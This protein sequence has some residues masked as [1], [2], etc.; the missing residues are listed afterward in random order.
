[1]GLS[2]AAKT[3]VRANE[4]RGHDEF[5]DLLRQNVETFAN[6]PGSQQP[7]CPQLD[8][9]LELL[10]TRSLFPIGTVGTVIPVDT[11]AES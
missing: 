5:T 1:M 8:C 2:A 4:R 7:S 3:R 10:A 11:A 6:D 9:E